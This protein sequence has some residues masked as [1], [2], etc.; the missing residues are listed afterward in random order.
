MSDAAVDVL[1]IGAGPAGLSAAR[2]LAE[3][4]IAKV[5]VVDREDEPGGI[6]RFCPH[7]TFGLGDYFRPM[8]GPSYARRLAKL[9]DPGLIRTSTTVTA[10]RPGL[11][12]LL[13]SRAGEAEL[14]AK[15][16]LLATGIRE[17]PR[18]ARLVSGDR[19]LRVM[20]TGALQR[21][22][23]VSHRL[24]FKRPLIVG[25]ELVSFSAVLTLR[26]C[27][28]KP[29]AMV[30]SAERI[31]TLRPADVL[32][33]LLLGTPVLTATRVVSI[34]SAKDDASRLE[35]VTLE[36]RSGG[37]SSLAC[38]A[39]IF[40][41]GFVPEASLLSSMHEMIDAG[42]GG[43]SIDQMWRLADPG[44]YAAGNVLR[45]IETAGWSAREGAAAA[46][47]IVND[48]EQRSPKPERRV[49]VAVSGP[50]KLILPSAISV[51][52]PRPGPLQMSVRMKRPAT[53]RLT[54]DVDGSTIWRS[55]PLTAL[56]ERR[57]RLTRNLPD[58][59][60]AARLTVGFEE[61]PG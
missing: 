12:A 19:P 40:T 29:V 48:L 5:A 11:S 8:S 31:Q 46:H 21:M 7:P 20:T 22:V 10:I 25:T 27:G 51:P 49:P 32:T 17:T 53:G 52:G 56:P 47:A 55:G 14:H 28:V 45:S 30:E 9:V 39:V 61:T 23:A 35:S 16:I 18:A 24:P 4:G 26:D 38:D 59:S 2:V 42:S 34:N 60:N 41:G 6:P 50:V 57:L 36:A 13:S 54:L 44:L 1:V 43:P 37:R 33:R 15:R 58:L 3:R